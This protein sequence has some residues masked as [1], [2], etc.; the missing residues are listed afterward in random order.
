MKEELEDF[1]EDLA[2]EELF[3]E[4]NRQIL[5]GI[6]SGKLSGIT[7]AQECIC[8]V[9]EERL[10]KIQKNI[11]I[12]LEGLRNP[13]VKYKDLAG[14]EDLLIESRLLGGLPFYAIRITGKCHIE[15]DE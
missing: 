10:T 5:R 8:N 7:T 14:L 4:A 2:V 11:S 6:I 1:A 13:E 15:K 12:I 9:L 3:E